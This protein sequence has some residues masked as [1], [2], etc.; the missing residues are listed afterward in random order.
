MGAGGSVTSAVVVKVTLA[1]ADGPPLLVQMSV[2]VC[3][4]TAVAVMTL[5]PLAGNVPSQ[6]PEA[7][8][9][10]APADDHEIV[11]EAPTRTELE[12]RLSEGTGGGAPEVANSTT[13]PAADVPAVLE[14]V[15]V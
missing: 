8:Q 3:V 1:A 11:V 15:S 5:L 4:P 13:E 9:F 2:K 12:A 6:L 14:Q 7:V 10:V